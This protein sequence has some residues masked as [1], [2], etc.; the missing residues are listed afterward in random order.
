MHPMIGLEVHIS[1]NTHTKLFCSC[2]LP[3][4]G[5]EPNTKTCDTCVGFP[6]SKPVVNKKAIAYALKLCL[7]LHCAISP[8]VVFSRKVY[9]Y[10]DMGKN[11]Q[12][13]QYEQPLG[14]NGKLNIGDKEITLT[15]IHIEEDPAALLHQGSTVLV[16]YNRSGKPLCEIVTAP[17]FESADEAR[18]FLKRLITIL[19]Y[20][21]IFDQK[22]GVIKADANVSIKGYERAEIKNITGFKEI[23]RAINYEIERQRVL[24]REHQGLQHRE[25][26]GWDKEKGVTLFQ[27]KK[28]EE[29]DYGYILDTDLAPIDISEKTIRQT[30]AALPELPQ[31]KS[32]RYHA[33]LHLKQDDAEVIANDYALATLFEKAVNTIDPS[34]AAEWIR[35]EVTRILNYNKKTLEETF[36]EK[37]LLKL[38]TLIQNK[39]IT[40]RTG[41][42]II[43]LLSNHDIDIGSYI[44]EHHL[45]LV[46]DEGAVEDAC[47]KILEENKQAAQHYRQ[48][49]EKAFSYLVGECMKATKGRANPQTIHAAL[50]KLLS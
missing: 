17:D 35:R 21:D 6:G 2:P 46:E 38:L 50:K 16:D 8:E 32:Q 47:K 18:E 12:I 4:E 25:T 39:K 34:F 43:E 7:A 40:R 5:D 36:I 44:K 3:K 14:S 41:Q 49:E 48:G 37:H 11:Y 10:P 28:E 22:E 20:L 33:T 19:I 30:K 23:E 45:E 29:Q 13:T 15:R 26:R 9:F 1:L 31:E 24:I 27:R 42:K